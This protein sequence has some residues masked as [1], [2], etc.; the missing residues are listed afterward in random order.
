MYIFTLNK[1][2][3]LVLLIKNL[4]DAKIFGLNDPERT[5]WAS[6]GRWLGLGRNVPRLF[7]E[8]GIGPNCRLRWTSVNK[9]KILYY[10]LSQFKLYYNITDRSAT[11]KIWQAR[12]PQWQPHHRRCF[13]FFKIQARPRPWGPWGLE[14]FQYF[15][16]K[17][18]I[19][20]LMHLLEISIF[21]NFCFEL[22]FWICLNWCKC[23]L[24][25]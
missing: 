22:A 3:Y 13:L 20:P 12:P 11:A 10:F 21:S 7:D 24:L 17:L 1:F 8:F 23:P 4:L 18:G 9:G 15:L 5:R 19:K 16:I 6:G 25:S 2:I 14:T